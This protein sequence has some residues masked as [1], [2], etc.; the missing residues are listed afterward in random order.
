M[1]AEVPDLE[2]LRYAVVLRSLTAGTGSFTR[3]PLRH[4][5]APADRAGGGGGAGRLT[6]YGCTGSRRRL[7][8]FMQ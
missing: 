1:R 3:R 8:L 4:E 2:L 6:R 5:P 7:T